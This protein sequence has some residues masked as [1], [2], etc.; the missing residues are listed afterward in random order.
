M[1]F[2]NVLV[3]LKHYTK[4]FS[5]IEYNWAMTSTES[6]FFTKFV[7]FCV[8]QMNKKC[9]ISKTHP[10]AI[11]DNFF[12]YGFVVNFIRSFNYVELI[13]I[14]PKKKN[15]Y[16]NETIKWIAF[17]KMT[18]FALFYVWKRENQQNISNNIICILK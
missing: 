14:P 7:F 6:F 5:L 4:T 15:Y 13:I 1:R 2:Y 12:S 8:Q 10:S 17:K 18:E 11:L 9:A 16:Y 3:H